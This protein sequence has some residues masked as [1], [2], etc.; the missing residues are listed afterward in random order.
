MKLIA[1]CAAGIEGVLGNEM[2]HLGYSGNV[3]N[4]RVRFEGDFDDVIK[5]NLWLRTADRI[6][7]VLSEFYAKTFDELFEGVKSIPWEKWLALDSAFPVSGK[8]QKSQLH[9]VPSIQAIAKKAIVERMNQIYHRRTKFPE[10][11]AL[12]PIEVSINKNKVMTTLDTSGSSLFK[13]GYRVDKGGAPLKENMAAAL[14]LLSHWYPEY[15]FVD[16]TCGSGTIVIEAAM[17]G[18]NIAPGLKRN[19]AFENWQQVSQN[20]IQRQ[21]EDARKQIDLDKQLDI[22]GYDIDGRMVNIATVNA[23]AAGVLSKI[24]FKQ[25]ALKDFKTE[26][27][28]GVIV[29]NPPYGQRLSDRDSV[30][31]LYKQMGE[32]YRPLTTWSKYILTSDLSFEKYYGQN[33]TKKRKLYNGSLR[34]DLFQYWGKREH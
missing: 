8:S 28:N 14:V 3:E 15:P 25:L 32:V 4:G 10:T 20:R 24:K 27:K 11:G 34:T 6:K 31:V 19:F 9:N 12:Y 29:A 7:I 22:S 17:L 13:R 16:S 30:H 18:C 2:K 33:A 5:L 1:T 21:K 26:K 23:K